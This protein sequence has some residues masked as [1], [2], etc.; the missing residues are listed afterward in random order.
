MKHEKGKDNH[1]DQMTIEIMCTNL[2]EIRIKNKY[3]Y[4]YSVGLL[5]ALQKIDVKNAGSR[6]FPPGSG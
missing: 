6:F 2:G 1:I 5:V 3:M 4:I